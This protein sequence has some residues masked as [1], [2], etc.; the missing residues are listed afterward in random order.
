M[1]V[2]IAFLRGINVG[3]NKKVSMAGLKAAM[4]AAGFAPVKTHLNSGNVVFQAGA[5]SDAKAA[6]AVRAAVRQSAGVECHVMVRSAAELRE[7]FAA[8][9]FP[10]TDGSRM[11]IT[12]LD[13]APDRGGVESL[14]ARIAGPERLQAEG[15]V[16][17]GSFPDG[18]SASELFKLDW[19]RLL[20]VELTARNR[21]TVQ[22]L[23]EIA[24]AMGG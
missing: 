10:E 6:D 18:V 14:Q 19:R 13:G 1:A 11:Q 23:V 22:K 21:N 15:A 9:P 2:R 5:L 12:F 16:L 8:D 17:Y 3:G 7:A 4:E 24:E 20:G